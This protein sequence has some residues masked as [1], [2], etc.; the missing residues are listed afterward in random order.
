MNYIF[1]P[2]VNILFSL[3]WISLPSINLKD[4]PIE[5]YIIFF[6]VLCIMR[7]LEYFTN[8]RQTVVLDA[9]TYLKIRQEEGEKSATELREQL[10]LER[11]ETD[12]KFLG[13]KSVQKQ[14]LDEK[15]DQSYLERTRGYGQGNVRIGTTFDLNEDIYSLGFIS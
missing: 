1:I 5:C 10:I 6:L 2:I 14:I 15:G 9:R 7:I 8:I 13:L 12:E 4:E 3:Y 11:K